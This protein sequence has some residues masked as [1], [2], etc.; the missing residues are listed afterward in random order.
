MYIALN[1]GALGIKATLERQLELAASNGFKGVYVDI[2]VVSK[3]GI[4]RVSAMFKEKGLV[5]AA[6]SFPFDLLGDERSYE[7]GL[8]ELPRTA[9]MAKQLGCLRTSTYILSFSDTL[10]WEKNYELHVKRI[11]PAAEIL[12]ERGCLLGLEFLGPKTLRE[13]HRYE[14]IHTMEGMLELCRSVGTGN[15]GLLLDSWHWYTSHG[16]VDELEGLAG[17]DVVDVHVN[18]APE[19]VPIDEQVDNVRRMPGETGVIDIAGFLRAL[20]KAGYAGPV[21]AE[22]FVAEL[23]RMRDEEAARLTAE[24]L[25][26][27]WSMA[28]LK[29]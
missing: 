22:P 10:P 25:R 9:D 15:M 16:T 2:G 8:A 1:A 26:K 14:F 28:K 23:G 3:I 12:A 11:A 4:D 17:E 24:S 7:K 29:L 18:D 21:M 27:I 13:G 20:D 19:G 6:W 5:P